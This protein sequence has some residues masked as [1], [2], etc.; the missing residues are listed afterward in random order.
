M[1]GSG[2]VA[3]LVSQRYVNQRAELEFLRRKLEELYSTVN[4]FS[5][6]QQAYYTK[7][8]PQWTLPNLIDISQSKDAVEQRYKDFGTIVMLVNLYFRDAIPYMENLSNAHKDLSKLYGELNLNPQR[9]FQ[10]GDS[11]AL[12][13][14][15]ALER[16][17]TVRRVFLEYLGTTYAHRLSK[18]RFFRR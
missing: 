3:A 15:T 11:L 6:S 9:E 17:E 12:S 4:W 2:V 16:F 18:V 7:K 10:A 5:V 8:Q 13:L 14:N 1:V